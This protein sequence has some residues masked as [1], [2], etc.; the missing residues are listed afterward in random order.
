[1]KGKQKRT[2]PFYRGGGPAYRVRCEKTIRDGYN[3]DF[4]FYSD[5]NEPNIEAELKISLRSGG[6]AIGKALQKAVAG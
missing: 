6:D 5:A 2:S 4:N 3:K 1:V